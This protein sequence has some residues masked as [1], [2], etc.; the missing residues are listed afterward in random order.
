MVKVYYLYGT[1]KKQKAFTMKTKIV[2][3]SYNQNDNL[4][5][6]PSL[7]EMIPEKHPKDS[8]RDTRQAR[9]LRDRIHLQRRR[10]EQLPSAYATESHRVLLHE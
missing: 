9:D 1:N 10:Y 6:P 2:Y 8:Q 5:F 3:K 4:L 7:G